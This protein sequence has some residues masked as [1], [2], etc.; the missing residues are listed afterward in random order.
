MYCT[1]R[2]LEIRLSILQRL[3]YFCNDFC[4][5]YMTAVRQHIT[6][7]ASAVQIIIHKTQPNLHSGY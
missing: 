7:Y 1:C 6:L 4:I 5:R 2:N 3:V